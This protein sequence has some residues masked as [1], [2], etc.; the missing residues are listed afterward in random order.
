M[1]GIHQTPVALQGSC[2]GRGRAACALELRRLFPYSCVRLALRQAAAAALHVPLL[3]VLLLLFLQHP[4][5]ARWTGAV[6]ANT[7]P[8]TTRPSM[9][10]LLAPRVP[11]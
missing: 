3:L 2:K 6:P 10:P 11:W 1:Q 9:L 7:E 4:P 5:R 8:T